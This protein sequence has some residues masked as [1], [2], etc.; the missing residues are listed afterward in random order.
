MN[1]SLGAVREDELVVQFERQV[2]PALEDDL[3][4]AVDELVH[5]ALRPREVLRDL[6]GT[7]KLLGADQLDDQPGWQFNSIFSARKTCPR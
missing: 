7:V 4:Q 2:G 1:L 5:V 3:W 6:P